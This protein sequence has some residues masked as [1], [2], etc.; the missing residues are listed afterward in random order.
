M[1]SRLM[2]VVVIGAALAASPAIAQSNDG[3]APKAASQSSQA[4]PSTTP[5]KGEDIVTQQAQ[6]EWRASKLIGVSVYD[7]ENKK[8]GDIKE[9]LMGH[10]GSAKSVVI[11]IGGFLGIGTK[12]IAV[13]FSALQWKTENREVPAA[14]AGATNPVASTGGGK[15]PMQKVDSGA[16]EAH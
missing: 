12:N 14:D 13:P 16:V 6:D 9:V 10:D 3:S 5:P 11:G 2:Y 4:P 1:N 8:V 15:P 7:P